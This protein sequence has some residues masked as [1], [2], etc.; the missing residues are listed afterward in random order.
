MN[1]EWTAASFLA[2]AKGWI[3]K[4]LGELGYQRTGEIQQPHIAWWSTVLRVPTDAG[5]LWFKAAG[6]DGAH[7]AR[8]TPYLTSLLSGEIVEVLASDE[9]RGWL[10]ERDAGTRLR[11]LGDGVPQVDH[12]E[13]LLPRYAELQIQ[14]APH[15][16][17]LLAMDVPDR[18]LSLLPGEL[19]TLLE[20]PEHLLLGE[21]DG[22]SA[23]QLRRLRQ[24][25]AAFATQCERLAAVGLPETIQHDDLN[26]GNVFVREGHYLPFDWGDACISHPFHS[27]VVVLR[28][29]AY[30]QG[31]APG[32]QEVRRLL[33]AYLE[34]WQRFASPVE[35][36]AA[37]DLARQTGT[38]QRALAW[39]SSVMGMPA[40]VRAEY[41]DSIPYGL[42]LYLQN[43]P[44]GTWDDGSF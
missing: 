6:L 18:R 22:I 23:E 30:R 19:A 2:E 15:V 10:L 13:R 38:V 27:L 16:D 33:D 3:D 4:R 5:I 11:E 14:A 20:E 44:W 25:L 29:G 43:A 26:D 24:D 35:L 12:W 32:G 9:A 37:A 17:R 40:E 36:Q 7:E 39:R 8:L 42:R 31:W 28:A 1:P 21:T 34:P 41:V